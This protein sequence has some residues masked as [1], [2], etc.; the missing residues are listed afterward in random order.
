MVF[1][2]FLSFFFFNVSL[3]VFERHTP[4]LSFPVSPMVFVAQF[5]SVRIFRKAFVPL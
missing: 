4:N 3:T 1:G 5:Y 2:G